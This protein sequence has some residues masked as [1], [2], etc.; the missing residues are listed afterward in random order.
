MLHEKQYSEIQDYVPKTKDLEYHFFCNSS[1]L[2]LVD[3]LN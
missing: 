1:L 3:L 2:N